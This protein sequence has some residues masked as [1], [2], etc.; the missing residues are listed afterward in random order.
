MRE[1]DIQSAVLI[2]LSEQGHYCLR[3]NSGQFWG[4]E[5]MSHDGSMLLLKHPTKIQGAVKGTADIVGCV[6]VVV[7]PQMV[8]KTVAVFT[9]IEVKQPG[10]KAKPHQENYLALMRSRGAIAGIATSSD[11]ALSIINNK[12]HQWQGGRRND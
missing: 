6:Q 3:V 9:A 8:G 5:V 2:A 10:E 11:E 4:G 7:T 12:V 1:A